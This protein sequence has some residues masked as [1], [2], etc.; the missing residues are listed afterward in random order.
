MLPATRRALL[1]TG[2]CRPALRKA[3]AQA[4][5]PARSVTLVIPY[6]PGGGTDVIGRA[7]ATGL[8]RA[9]GQPAIVE[10]R[11]GCATSIGSTAVA[12]TRPDGYVLLLGSNSLAINPALQPSLTPR[13]PIRELAPIGLVYRS[14]LLLLHPS[15]PARTLPEFLDHARASPGALNYGSSSNGS[16]SHLIF[17]L[18][19]HRAGLVLE[20]VPYRGAAPALLDLR[21]GRIQALFNSAMLAQPLLR[22]GAIR[23]LAT[24][25]RSRSPTMPDLPAV[26]ETLP[27]FDAVFWQGLF[28]PAG[29]PAPVLA[30]LSAARWARRSRMP[31]CARARRLNAGRSWPARPP[32]WP[33]CWR[34]KPPPGAR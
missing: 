11:A 3:G 2:M 1:A 31:P 5:Y 4:T 9:I 15:V 13:D 8:E 25:S 27:G 21:A 24:S 12:Q 10:N 17:A 29:T 26:A 33:P 30:A 14:P 19:A 28:A 16:A 7:V 22:E 34:R 6:P 20:H 23:A 32:I 18:L